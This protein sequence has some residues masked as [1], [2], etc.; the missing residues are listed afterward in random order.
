MSSLV[1]ET[2]PRIRL[3]MLR[4]GAHAPARASS[5]AAGYDLRAPD[6][7]TFV[8]PPGGRRLVKMGFA[9]S[10][11]VGWLMWVVPRSGLS[12]KLDVGVGNSPGLVDS[13][14]RGEVGVIVVNRGTEP[15][16]I[17]AGD[18][19]AQVV[20]QKH[21]SPEFDVLSD[22]EELDETERGVGGFGST[23]RS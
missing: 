14:Y 11:P 19:V 12:L 2:S 10:L 6:D 17:Q 23:G 7:A 3:K 4:Q 20:F 8:I 1:Y 5:G 18:R 21:E 16:E 15:F 9:L 22:E 13:D